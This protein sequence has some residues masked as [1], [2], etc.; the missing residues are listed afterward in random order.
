MSDGMNRRKFLKVL[1]VTG[2]GASVM[3]G[4]SSDQVEKLIP[5]L[6][7]IEDQIP[8]TAVYYASTCRDCPA[9]CGTHVRVREGRA[10][11][12][13]GNPEHPVNRGRLCARGQA[14]LQGTYNPDRIR[15]PL[16]RAADGS[17]EPISWDDAM[18][19]LFAQLD[20]AGNGIV[21]LTGDERG[22][23][24]HLIGDWLAAFGGGRHVVF[25]PFGYEALRQAGQEVFGEADGLPEYRLEHAEYVL[26]FGA[27]FLE[28]WRSPT[29]QTRGFVAARGYRDGR[30]G[31][32]VHVEPRLSMT[33]MSADEW[34]A[35]RPGTEALVALSV[36]HVVAHHHAQ[37]AP[38]DAAALRPLLAAYEPEDT[39][40][41]TG[42]SSE[43]IHRLAEEF[44]AVPS[45]ALPGGIGTQ[46]P[47]AR[48][49][50]VATHVLN[51][52]AG[53]VGRSVVFAGVGLEA[54][55]RYADFA[56][57]VENARAGAIRVLLVHGA[58]PVHG[59]PGRLA[60]A[61]ALGAI[62][63]KV[64]FSR[65]LDETTQLADL[66]LPDHDPVEQWNDYVSGDGSVRSLQQPVMQPVFDT[67]Q[68][69]D[70]LIAVARRAG[71]AIAERFALGGATQGLYKAYLQEQWRGVQRAVGDRAS[72]DAFWRDALQRGGVWTEARARSVRLSRGLA[73]GTPSWA[74][75]DG[76]FALITYPSLSLFDGRGANRPWLQE[77]P[78][79]VTKITW[80][81][82]VEIHPETA[83]RL[84]ILE[85]DLIEV[86][87]EAGSV[88]VPAYVYPGVRPDVVAMPL[89][90]GHTAYGRYAQGRGANPYALLDAAPTAFG[91]VN[92][93]AAVAVRP[94]GRHERLAKTEGKNRQL[95][96]GIAQAVTLAGIA[97]GEPEHGAHA[98][99]AAPIPQREEHV[100]EE[101]AEAQAEARQYGPYVFETTRW[102]M[103]VD[104]AR[105]TGCSACVTACSAENNVPFVGPDQVRRGREMQWIRIER[106]FEGGEHG[107]PL[108]ARFVPMM[109]QHCGNAPCEP[110]CPVFAA[111]HTPDGLNGQVYN[112]CVGTRYCGNNC[113]YKVRYFNWYDMSTAADPRT[114]A[115]PEPMHWLLN[116]DVTVRSKG[117][118][119]KCT[120][121]VQRIRGSQH[122]ARLEGR[123]LTD[124]EVR[125][126]CE[127]TCP[128]D[129]IVFGNLADPASRVAQLA[130]DA[131]G[132]R[133]LD[134]LNTKPA[135]T[136]LMKVRNV[137]EG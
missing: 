63:F 98:E 119:E 27:D 30:M 21:F 10:V 91:G 124:G 32:Y 47:D 28:T 16:A 128:A 114:F 2:G 85:G 48:L 15:G 136:Y 60:A 134:G 127:Q 3:A 62:P 12:I 117:V 9:G 61:D 67:R 1:G 126:A 92:H 95:G 56:G 31:R 59:T 53:N 5:Y 132:Y 102:A 36:A 122:Q 108:E 90:Q 24:A 7:P 104:L 81:T 65:F 51:Y 107:E 87:S 23:F 84:G 80:G 33:A 89:G 70:V 130:Q 14:A 125:T 20:G 110:V 135:V 86:A 131:R 49:T 37:R 88:E 118:M 99:H 82:W 103:A 55:S 116:P 42:V 54:V 40:E 39:A 43:T 64:S 120:F 52:L 97:G 111:Y 26:S 106:Y 123:V 74:L 72:F 22:T 34:V 18:A 76:Q 115:W 41:R 83:A 6:V 69:G 44:T 46:H 78:D 121:C 35:P 112:R 38:T 96:R 29:A 105:C 4:C 19:R 100:V 101:V 133:V 25:E 17:F 113:P 13:E 50:A 71:G 93:Y 79:P 45:V 66:V 58:N 8:G 11:K 94:T 57:F 73:L 75:P 129:A 68:T 137:V 109:C 77:L